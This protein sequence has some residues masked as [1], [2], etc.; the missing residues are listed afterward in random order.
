MGNHDHGHSL[1]SKGFHDLKDFAY[2][3]W[4]K[5][6]SC[7]VKKHYFWRHCQS[8]GNGDSLLLPTAKLVR[9][10]VGLFRNANFFQ[11]GHGDLR[12]LFFLPVPD[13][14]LCQI[15]IFQDG[16]VREKVKGLEDHAYLFTNL[17]AV[18]LVVIERYPVD[19]N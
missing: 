12:G 17:Q 3:F 1:P 10:N 16:Q 2:H 8:P 14:H 15:D 19:N 9:I 13:Q 5:G 18:F 11:Q 6:T 7:F 4:I